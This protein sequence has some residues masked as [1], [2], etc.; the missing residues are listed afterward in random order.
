M[1][2]ESF[3]EE[4]ADVSDE[5]DVPN[6][7]DEEEEGE[8]DQENIPDLINDDVEEEA[9]EEDSDD[10]IVGRK[11]RRR[12]IDDRLEEDDFDLIEENLGVKIDRKKR[13]RVQQ[14]SDEEDSG[15]EREDEGPNPEDEREAIAKE[16]FE[17][18]EDDE[19]EAEERSR[20]Q[21]PDPVAVQDEY[22]ESESDESD[23]D[24]FIVDDN[25]QPISGKKKKGH[26]HKYTDA[27]LQE[28]QDIF[29]VDFDFD[30]FQDY[31]DSDV[32][33]EEEDYDVDYEEDEGED[34][35][36]RRPKKAGR[37]K[38][39]KKSIYDVFE[40]SD[41]ERRHFTDF[42]EEIRTADIPERFQLRQV[43]I[44]KADDAE[45]EEEAEWIYRQA[46]VN[47]TI[48]NQDIGD[49]SDGY[50]NNLHN[51]RPP[52]TKGKTREALHFIRNQN[53]EV[54]FI[55]F[56]RKEYVEPELNF[57][58]LYRVYHWDAKWCQL[59]SRKDN[60]KK[61]LE[62]MQNYQYEV[63]ANSD[64]E[65][66]SDK[67]RPLTEADLDRLNDV[68]TVD[69][70]KDVYMHFLLYY[71]RD[72]PKMQEMM[73]KK[74]KKK[75]TIKVIRKVKV[76][77]PKEKP[78][79][80]DKEEKEEGEEDDEEEEEV[81]EE[82]E[83]EMEVDDDEEET[84]GTTHDIKQANRNSMY[85]LCS[86]AGLDGLAKKYGL[87]P[88]QFGENLRDNY[89]RYDPE[90]H[91]AEPRDAAME[92]ITSKFDV[93]ERVLK[94]A[95]YMV[96]LQLAHDPMVRQCVRQT[97]YER[98]KISVKPTKKGFKEIDENHPCYSMKYLLNKQVKDLYMDQF[99]KL[100]Q[101]EEEGLLTI[102]MSLDM[103]VRS[104]DNYGSHTFLDE[105]RQLYY[106][107]EFSNHVQLWNEERGKALEIAFENILYPAFAKELRAKLI[108][109]A[110]FGIMRHC[111]R[112][113]YNWL[114]VSPYQADQQMDY[115]DDDD[116]DYES[117]RAGLRVLGVAHPPDL[118]AAT[119][120]V[121]IDGKGEVSEFL[122]LPHFLRRSR[123]WS[124]R[125]RDLKQADIESLKKFLIEKK[126]HVVAVA[127]ESR[128]TL[129]VIEDIKRCITE[130][131]TEQQM[132]PINVE[133]VDSNVANIF[134]NSK[135]AETE[136]LE[137]PPCLRKAIS[138][139]RRLQD[140]LQEF[141]RLCNVDE[142]VLC[143]RFHPLQDLV[144]QELLNENLYQE[145]IFR[146][147]EVGV[148]INQALAHHHTSST[149]QFICGLGA[150]KGEALLRTLKQQNIN[151]ENRNQ[152]VM[153]C[154]LGPTV[155]IN[156]AG[157]IKI[158]T[159]SVGDSSDSYIEVLDSTRIHP[160]TYEWARKMAVDALEYDESAEDANPAEAL[161]EILDNPDKLKDLDLDAFAEELKR[162]GYGNKS[163]TL[164]DIRAELNSRYKDFRVPYRAPSPEETFSLLTKETP[165]TFYRGKMMVVKVQNI[166]RRKPRTDQLEQ[167]NPIRDDETGY[168]QCP[169]CLRGDFPELSE[170][171]SHFD[172]DKCPGQAMGV[173]VRLDN[174]LSGFIPTKF[175]SDKKVN[176][177]EERVQPQMTLHARVSR[178]DIERFQVDLTCRSSD[179]R[180]ERGEW[181]PPK[182]TYYDHETADSEKRQDEEQKEKIS[183]SAYL[184]R[185]IIHPSFHNITFKQ[186]ESM[187]EGA[188]VGE[189]I[190]RPSSKG[191][192]H[193][194]ATW[195]ID[196]GIYQHIDVKEEGKDKDFNLGKSLL[197]ND[198]EY[199]DLDEIIA[200]HI[201][202]MAAFVRD[203]QQH[204]Y[205]R[206][207]EGGNKEIMNKILSAE[208]KK[209]PSRIPYFMSFVKEYPGK[210]LL[211]YQPR[212]KPKHEY[213]TV[214]PDGFRYRGQVQSSIN[215]LHRWF[216]EH[217]RDPIPGVS[218]TPA[219]THRTPMSVLADGT[220]VAWGTTPLI[221]KTGTTFTGVYAT[222]NM[223]SHT[224]RQ[225][226]GTPSIN[227][228]AAAARYS[229]FAG[230]SS[231][232]YTTP[233]IMTPQYGGVQTPQTNSVNR[234]PQINPARTPSYSRTPQYP[235]TPRQNQSGQN[236]RSTPSTA[237]QVVNAIQQVGQRTPQGSARATPNASA[238]AVDWA[239]QAAQWAKRRQAG[240]SPSVAPSPAYGRSP[241]VGSRG[242]MTPSSMAEPSPMVLATPAS[243]VHG[244]ATPL[245]DES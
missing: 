240:R 96:A 244:D 120:G 89:Q 32:D 81:E 199:E 173:R 208:K 150:R 230:G 160:E 57:N 91:P 231:Y 142:D 171:W 34:M 188:E 123:S 176:N 224:P 30:E 116:D 56:Y 111:S 122:R 40:P 53:Y 137:F 49:N 14:L 43:P 5:E 159:T 227:A 225:T 205:Y 114:K 179:L 165:E 216:K 151:L 200:R 182:D 168:W 36:Q 245:I 112:Q 121:I 22:A 140:P 191:A 143:L 42:D 2:K 220:P 153:G 38:A 25:G 101:A 1:D 100:T 28:A 59:K 97:Y 211:S 197:I 210:F 45:L 115:D 237:Q 186:A 217:F 60:L 214:T 41:L 20:P 184:K 102:K 198:E 13:R 166:A 145:F 167:A 241:R 222:P 72:I 39:P 202:P 146:A 83:E 119:F 154:Q 234:T 54:P 109:E 209:N 71:G 163:I 195:K 16:I 65:M 50:F 133:L 58:D 48:S 93:E 203:V 10:E 164:Y 138:V 37:A 238:A 233:Q 95:R 47:P 21:R 213:V 29:G 187:M 77:R 66:L 69:K 23:P 6:S 104:N 17:G 46:F 218:Y 128:Q 148:D 106:R 117:G 189:V 62:K 177:P 172:G 239:K 152:L 236:W 68:D 149:V 204:K 80:E 242:G 194:T 86:E 87:T 78:E 103:E 129:D 201:Q 158:D 207:T 70:L 15:S 82:V 52:R 196:D 229:S 27:A 156:C 134:A 147:N 63:I 44:T 127:A 206:N 193:L 74:E 8:E 181:T 51:R 141:A 3:F 26:K 105:I 190:I 84:G 124:E 125:D 174:G 79:T 131:E 228:A 169:F 110:K 183:K 221:Q 19:E 136:F 180:D 175:L 232:P 108:E 61:L 107:D 31:K 118:D 76:K 223:L 90:Q 243:T 215:A 18:G 170:V 99:L 226:P 94:A 4:E 113:L 178:I 92:Y 75:K 132:A 155:F 24:D 55:A 98:A 35:G 219:S 185:V 7:S 88:E 126:P 73:K 144:S 139:A 64:S 161:E 157:F 33:D 235:T 9:G 12:D 135:T 192:D 11:K 85:G 130:L 162:Q 67:V 212:N